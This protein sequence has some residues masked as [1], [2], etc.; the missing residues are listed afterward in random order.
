MKPTYLLLV[1][2]AELLFLLLGLVS[3]TALRL[4]NLFEALVPHLR[5][6]LCQDRI[7]PALAGDAIDP[8]STVLPT[9]PSLR[10]CPLLTMLSDRPTSQRH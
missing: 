1:K 5:A 3:S 7:A 6:Y 2:R 4:L 10:L 9:L 8:L